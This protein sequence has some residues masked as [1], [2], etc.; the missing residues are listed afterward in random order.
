MSIAVIENSIVINLVCYDSSN[1]QSSIEHLESRGYT[2]VVSDVA[3]IGDTWDGTNFISPPVPE[4]DPDP[5]TWLIDIGPFFDRFGV[6][7]L[8]ILMSEDLT[9]KAIVQDVQVRKWV[10]LQRADVA[11]AMD[12]LITKSLIDANDKVSIL[13]TPVQD[14][15]NLALK[16]LY[17]S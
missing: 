13:T 5:A 7:K 11:Q 12:I 4:P 6:K 14:H 3:R 8:P 9:V 1:L 15:E 2:C 10:D 16:K 17:F